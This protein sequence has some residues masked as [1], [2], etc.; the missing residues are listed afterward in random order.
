[1]PNVDQF[2]SISVLRLGGLWS[3]RR[4]VRAAKGCG[5]ICVSGV[6]VAAGALISG[7]AVADVVVVDSSWSCSAAAAAAAAPPTEFGL[8]MDGLV[9]LLLAVVMVVLLMSNRN[10]IISEFHEPRM[11]HGD[12]MWNGGGGLI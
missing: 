2:V 8:V 6:G 1:M 7:A 5:G 12:P 11:L 10:P 4:M 3:N 9:M